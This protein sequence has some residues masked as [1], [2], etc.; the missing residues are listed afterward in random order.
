M[1]VVIRL[2][3]LLK[4]FILISASKLSNQSST[5]STGTRKRKISLYSISNEAIRSETITNLAD[6]IR[7]GDDDHVLKLIENNSEMLDDLLTKIGIVFETHLRRDINTVISSADQQLYEQRENFNI[8]DQ[9]Y[10]TPF[11]L[12]IIA[13]QAKNILFFYFNG[14]FHRHK[15]R[16]ELIFHFLLFLFFIIKIF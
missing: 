15:L 5:V 11:H 13:Q 3:Y 6:A 9:M 16:I 8:S 1:Y 10:V 2:T 7:H 12:A 4:I 14:F